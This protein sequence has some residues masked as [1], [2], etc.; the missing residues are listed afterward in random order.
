MRE[1]THTLLCDGC[2]RMMAHTRFAI[3]SGFEEP[4]PVR[5]T[6]GMWDLCD[7]CKIPA[8]KWFDE[9]RKE[10]ARRKPA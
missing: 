2:G 7:E 8:E 6:Y 1:V 9:F 10:L 4:Q 3:S 5:G